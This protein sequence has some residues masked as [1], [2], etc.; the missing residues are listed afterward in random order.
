[1]MTE[2]RSDLITMVVVPTHIFRQETNHLSGYC[3]PYL[4][5]NF[6]NLTSNVSKG[7]LGDCLREFNKVDEYRFFGG[8]RR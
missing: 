4:I 3:F 7:V 2:E 8:R 1:M 5:S 6:T